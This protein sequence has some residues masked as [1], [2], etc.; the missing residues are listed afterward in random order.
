MTKKFWQYRVRQRIL[1]TV[2]LLAALSLFLLLGGGKAIPVGSWG[3][4]FQQEGGS[5]HRHRQQ[6]RP[7][8]L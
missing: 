1:I 7:L 8:R 6:R 2:C 5:A 4:S 3:L